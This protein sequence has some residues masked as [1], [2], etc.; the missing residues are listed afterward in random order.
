PA[1]QKAPSDVGS[2]VEIITGIKIDPKSE[3]DR[4]EDI[5]TKCINPAGKTI[6]PQM[7]KGLAFGE[8]EAENGNGI[9]LPKDHFDQVANTIQS[10]W[11]F[12]QKVS[13]DDEPQDVEDSKSVQTTSEQRGEAKEV[14]KTETQERA[15]K[16]QLVTNMFFDTPIRQA[17]ADISAQ[18]GVIILPDISVQGIVTCELQDVPIKRALEIVLSCGNFAFRQMNG[19]ILVGS[20][21]SESPSFSR[22][23][24]I[25]RMKMNYVKAEEAV[26]ML[27]DS[28]QT[29][30]KANVTSNTVSVTAPAELLERIM[31]NLKLIDQPSRHVMLDAR[32]VSLQRGDLLNLGVQWNW[33]GISAGTFSDSEH[34]GGGAPERVNWPWGVQIGY[35]PGQEFTNSLMMTLNLLA[36][37]HEATVIASPQVLAQ[38]GQ[39]AEI[40][41]VT[42]E[43][44]KISQESYMYTRFE[45]ETIET[46]TT[47]TITP[48]IGD[49]N[50]ITLEIVTEVS[51]VIARGDDNLPV[52]TRR[53]TKN[54]VRIEDGGTAA[55]AG[56]MDTRK[57]SEKSQAP[58]LASLPLVG[59]LFR[60]TG[61]IESAR[62]VSVFIT[63]RL[64][65]ENGLAG[66]GA[67]EERIQIGP[68]GE[69]FRKA[70]EESLSLMNAKR[71]MCACQPSVGPP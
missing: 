54:T 25:R 57:R 19:Y 49:N 38:D 4:P 71:T 42:E 30:A 47:L 32:I 2:I 24:E 53:T 1:T 40:K 51:D 31:S 14:P 46:G 21:D 64:M 6:E 63:A 66:P 23:S 3:P 37:N 50:E 33:P 5:G 22:L 8:L 28:V 65:P 56:L 17:L 12:L 55:V 35:T 58:G 48:R 60:N 15:K 52:V 69:E 41:V 70:L 20:M 62:H 26:K 27:S 16:Q 59:G 61:E 13:E 9:L 29:Y 67:I 39:E 10:I 43:Y 36:E 44:F 18:T 34:H 7:E 45:L 11:M 68:A